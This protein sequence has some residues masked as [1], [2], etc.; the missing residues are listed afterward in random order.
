MFILETAALRHCLHH[1]AYV[2]IAV[3]QKS[4]SF[5][6]QTE[7][8][9]TQEALSNIKESNIKVHS[10]TNNIIFQVYFMD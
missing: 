8:F 6:S 5:N 1:A 3:S 10:P 7:V 4:E 2:H 9:Q